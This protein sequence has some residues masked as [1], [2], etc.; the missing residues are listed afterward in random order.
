MTGPY[1]SVDL[2]VRQNGARLTEMGLHCEI[3]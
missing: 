2:I 1:P 3:Y